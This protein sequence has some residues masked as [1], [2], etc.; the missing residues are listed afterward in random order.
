MISENSFLYG[1]VKRW[2]GTNYLLTKGKVKVA[3]ET[4]LSFLAYNFRRA[5]N[6]QGTDRS[7]SSEPGKTSLLL[8]LPL[9]PIYARTV[10]ILLAI[11][12]LNTLFL[13]SRSGDF[14][15]SPRKLQSKM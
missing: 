6:L 13:R 5:V 10:F 2:H 3:D 7:L 11:T 8:R 14:G 9:K 1:T 15:H 12:G 4:G